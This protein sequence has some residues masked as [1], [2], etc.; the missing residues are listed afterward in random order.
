MKLFQRHTL[1]E[2]SDR[3]QLGHTDIKTTRKHYGFT[4]PTKQRAVAGL[5]ARKIAT[6]LGGA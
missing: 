2:T 5:A 4:G 1:L 6:A 3:Y